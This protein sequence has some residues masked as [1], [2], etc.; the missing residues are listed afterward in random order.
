MQLN[1]GINEVE[2]RKQK[3]ICTERYRRRDEDQQMVISEIDDNIEEEC[4]IC[5]E[6]NN[7]VV[8]PTC[9]HAM[10]IKCYR[11]WYRFLLSFL[12]PSCII[13]IELFL[14]KYVV[15]HDQIKHALRMKR[16]AFRKLRSVVTVMHLDNMIIPEW[17]SPLC[18][19]GYFLVATNLFEFLWDV[20]QWSYHSKS[21]PGLP[22]SVP[23]VSAFLCCCALDVGLLIFT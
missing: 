9:S 15:L 8:L 1:E 5:M 21:W 13:V 20:T 6:V 12:P 22:C 23:S 2:D 4:G 3:A 17:E 7:K 19:S 18:S 16:H 14:W 10:C 11:D